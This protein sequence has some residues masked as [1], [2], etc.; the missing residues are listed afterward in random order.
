FV[1]LSKAAVTGLIGGLCGVGLGLTTGVLLGGLPSNGITLP[2]LFATGGLL[3][4]VASAP[5][6]ALAM[7]GIA[8]WVPAL[9]AARRDPAAILQGD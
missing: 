2:D 6:L 4:T 7:T 8:S 1:F 3:T 9:Y 5:L